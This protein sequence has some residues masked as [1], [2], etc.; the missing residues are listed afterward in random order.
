MK[1]TR[2]ME[3]LSTSVSAETS[4]PWKP[5]THYTGK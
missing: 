1:L 4:M 3:S 2:E 5:N